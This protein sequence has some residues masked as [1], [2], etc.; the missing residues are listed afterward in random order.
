MKLL[1]EVYQVWT[2]LTLPFTFYELWH[3]GFFFFFFFKLLYV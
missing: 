3:A 2:K 1:D